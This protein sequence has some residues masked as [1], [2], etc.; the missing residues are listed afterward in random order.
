MSAL[1]S[2]L[3]VSLVYGAFSIVF[4]W[5]SYL[6]I[7]AMRFMYVLLPLFFLLSLSLL[8]F[9]FLN[10]YNGMKNQTND[11]LHKYTH[12]TFFS[13]FLMGIYNGRDIFFPINNAFESPSISWN[14]RLKCTIYETVD[15]EPK[16]YML[17]ILLS[18][19]EQRP[20]RFISLK[21]VKTS[22]FQFKNRVLK[23][24]FQMICAGRF[25][26]MLLLNRGFP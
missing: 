2:W 24:Q 12:R 22:E 18:L 6:L 1:N 25:V 3:S 21:C 15:D 20:S 23:N 4:H 19:Y 9:F 13:F 8:S 7:P 26:C 10:A 11:I 14:R 17:R 5:Q 16:R